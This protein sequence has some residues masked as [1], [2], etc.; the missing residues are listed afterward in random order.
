[1]SL[2]ATPL[3]RAWASSSVQFVVEWALDHPAHA[4]VET[5][6]LGLILVL[7][8]RKSSRPSSLDLPLSK[9]EEDALLADWE[10]VPL[11]ESLSPSPGAER[12]VVVL[13]GPSASVVNVQNEA[14]GATVTALNL[15]STGFFGYQSHPEVI[16]AALECTS[17][18]G[19][20]ACGPRGFYGSLRPHLALEE[21]VAQFL[22]TDEAVLF[23]AEFQVAASVLPAF[24][25]PGDLLLMDSGLPF[26]WWTG[27]SLSRAEVREWAH[28]DAGALERVLQQVAQQGIFTAQRQRVFVVTEALSS[29]HGDIAPLAAIMALKQRYPFRIVLDESL[30]LG[31]LGAKG[32]GLREAAG[33]Q[34]HDVEL[35][36]FSLGHALGSVGGIA[37]GRADVCN[38]MRLNCTGYVFSCSSPPYVAQ[39][40]LSA[41]ALLQRGEGRAEL[42]ALLPLFHA[43]LAPA[44][45]PYLSVHGD[46]RSPSV[47]VR[48]AKAHSRGP[49][50]D[51]LL[52]QRIA[53]LA[54]AP[55]SKRGRR[56]TPP[57][58]VK[59]K[60]KEAAKETK[61][62]WQ[63]AEG[64]V[65]VA[66]P[67]YT[68]Q[69]KRAP[70]PSL[71]LSLHAQLPPDGLRAALAT[72]SRTVQEAFS[73]PAPAP[74]QD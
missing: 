55:S 2:L 51:G 64:R 9:A 59:A 46:S 56:E 19:V 13:A 27:A 45:A 24:A 5:L 28:N 7:L 73:A 8:L 49:V 63:Q 32:R 34:P 72:L 18:Y 62:T 52:L 20:G 60:S 37:A 6:L 42:S 66:L 21:S 4:L 14:T 16:S 40:A 61:E 17:V 23:S 11:I 50:Q 3:S 22:Q 25:K 43:E 15:A 38:H 30:S 26:A 74:V 10:P 58:S 1:M 71:R 53:A 33:L 29:N 35:L 31:V 41:L 70:P 57:R 65:L 12:G 44:L 48:V 69:D 54:L 67:S 39:A 68:Q 47:H 36:C